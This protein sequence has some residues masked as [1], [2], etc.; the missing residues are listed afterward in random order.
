M[1]PIVPHPIIYP[2][3][4]PY[5]G[6]AVYAYLYVTPEQEQPR[7]ATCDAT[8]LGRNPTQRDATYPICIATTA[9]R[10]AS[11]FLLSLL[12]RQGTLFGKYEK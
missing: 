12:P 2:V 3:S 1:I 10:A 8:Q 9:E 11:F 5:I 7:R 4:S 6:R